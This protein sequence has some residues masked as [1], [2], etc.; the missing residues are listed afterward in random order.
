MKQL[1]FAASEFA[2]KPK[3]TRREKFLLEMDAVVPWPRLLSV[4]ESHYL[5]GG[6][7][8]EDVGLIP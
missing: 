3:Q 4:V 6:S 8:L 5:K 1:S 2:K 7:T